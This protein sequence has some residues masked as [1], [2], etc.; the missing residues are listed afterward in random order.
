MNKISPLQALQA[1]WI[2]YKNRAGMYTAFA[3]FMFVI[4][5]VIGGVA[6]SIAAVFSGAGFLERAVVAVITGVFGAMLN[7]GWCHFARK[8]ERGDDVEFGDFFQGFKVNVRSLAAVSV[9]IA[10]STQLLSLLVPEE[11]L[12]MT[13]DAESQ[14]AEEVMMMFQDMQEVYVA[15][16]SNIMLYAVATAFLGLGLLFA[17]YRASLEGEDP[18]TAIQWSFSHA[19]PNTLRI[20]VL[21]FLVIIVTAVVAILTLGLGLLVLIPWI[22]LALYDAYD[23]VILEA[24]GPLGLDDKFISRKD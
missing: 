16:A 2:R 19:L 22:T 12:S 18:I 20:I 11:I 6:A 7:M 15:H 21:M 5:I 23:Q 3:V 9:V 10:L 24:S 17:Q 8:D 13:V 4:S 14:N 1:G